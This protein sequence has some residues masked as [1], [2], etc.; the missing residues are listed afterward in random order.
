MPR[1]KLWDAT[2]HRTYDAKHWGEVLRAL[3]DIGVVG[4]DPAGTHFLAR[5]G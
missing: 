1:G 3:K 2:K 4:Q 5:S